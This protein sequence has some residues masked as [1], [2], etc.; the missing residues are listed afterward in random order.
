VNIT[1][2]L[3]ANASTSPGPAAVCGRV[4]ILNRVNELS[5]SEAPRTFQRGVKSVETSKSL[6]MEDSYDFFS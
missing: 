6:F 2:C 1:S 3:A 5:V 4:E